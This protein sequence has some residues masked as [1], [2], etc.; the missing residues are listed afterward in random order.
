MKRFLT[1][2][3]L[4]AMTAGAANAQTLSAGMR[5]GA[6][7]NWQGTEHK[8]ISFEQSAFA[9][10]ESGHKWAF[11]AGIG[12]WGGAMKTGVGTV[13]PLDDYSYTDAHARVNTYEMNFSLQYDISCPYMQ[14]HC[15]VMRRMHTFISLDV[16]P[17][18]SRT[19]LLY[20]DNE[21]LFLPATDHISREFRLWTGLS[22]T[23]VYDLNEHINLVSNAGF[24]IDPARLIATP[25]NNY[26]TNARLSFQVGAAYKF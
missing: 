2:L 1:L 5:A 24:K 3:S 18:W 10:Y 13:G 15:P 22:E 14:Q 21:N 8:Y 20:K 19:N 17:S 4:A 26:Q 6:G 9:R 25:D 11:E 23:M 16:S 12:H 7:C